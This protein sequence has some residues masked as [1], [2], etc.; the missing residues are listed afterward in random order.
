M[1]QIRSDASSLPSTWSIREQFEI[2][3]DQ[4]RNS[5]S[6]DRVSRPRFDHVG[7]RSGIRSATR[8]EVWRRIRGCK[9]RRPRFSGPARVLA[10]RLLRFLM[11]S[12]RAVFHHF[13]RISATGARNVSEPGVTS[14]I[15]PKRPTIRR[16]SV[17]S[18]QSFSPTARA[19][20]V[21]FA[22]HPSLRD[23]SRGSID[24]PFSPK[25]RY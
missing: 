22:E 1:R 20:L 8:R 24:F 14:L 5:L 25:S 11:I 7:M 3:D 10:R 2:K 6:C 21:V 12:S 13:D 4:P 18:G 15:R 16:L 17:K 19:E 23:R 9:S